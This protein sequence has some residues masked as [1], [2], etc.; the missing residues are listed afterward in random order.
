MK[1]V[2]YRNYDQNILKEWQ[3]LWEKSA[4][5]SYVNSSDWFLSVIEIFGYKK[6]GIIAL[7][8]GEK[9]AA[10]GAL[11]EE[12]KYGIPCYTIAPG[13]FAC[14]LPFLIDIQDSQAIKSFTEALSEL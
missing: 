7:Y 2:I 14:G 4:Y 1:T 12:S 8:E 13:N 3:S 9:L 11:V 10:I 5:A 6:Y